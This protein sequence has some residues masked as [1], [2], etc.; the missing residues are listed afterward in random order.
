MLFRSLFSPYVGVDD[1][2]WY[3]LILSAMTGSTAYEDLEAPLIDCLL[4][5]DA[6]KRSTDFQMPVLF[7]SGSED[8]S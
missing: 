3:L 6:Y 7:I 2:R 5:F 8:W 4:D 1:V